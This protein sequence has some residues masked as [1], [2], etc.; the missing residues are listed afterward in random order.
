MN[1]LV[2][3]V[4]HAKSTKPFGR[5]EIHDIVEINGANPIERW[6]PVTSRSVQP[7]IFADLHVVLKYGKS[8]DVTELPTIVPVIDSG[9]RHPIGNHPEKQEPEDIKDKTNESGDMQRNGDVNDDDVIISLI[10]RGETL[11]NSIIESTAGLEVKEENSD[12]MEQEEERSVTGS[13]FKGIL[14]FHEEGDTTLAKP[15]ISFAAC[16]DDI[17][18]LCE[19]RSSIGSE[20]DDP[21]HD[22]TLLQDLFYANKESST[23]NESRQSVHVEIKENEPFNDKDENNTLE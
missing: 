18:L 7:V 2:L 1:V 16:E 20:S 6:Y 11:R 17:E 23:F 4:L 5:V 22:E 9:F 3:D 14:E 10:K 19:S 8:V 13:L 15:D 21:I 12:L